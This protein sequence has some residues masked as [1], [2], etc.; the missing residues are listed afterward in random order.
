MDLVGGYG[1]AYSY[2]MEVLCVVKEAR[3]PQLCWLM[4]RT[5]KLSGIYIVENTLAE[6]L[7]PRRDLELF[8]L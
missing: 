5:A 1:T 7:I 8:Q 4:Q 6:L 2:T 3:Q